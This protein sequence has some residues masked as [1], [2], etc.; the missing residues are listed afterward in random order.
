MVGPLPGRRT[1]QGWARLIELNQRF[2][3]VGLGSK[4]NGTPVAV[5]LALGPPTLVGQMWP[6]RQRKAKG[7][8]AR[9]R[10]GERVEL[11]AAEWQ[12]PS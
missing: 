5:K 1:R 7:E 10:E 9:E 12:I 11:T 2:D 3:P 6:L 8:R 4:I